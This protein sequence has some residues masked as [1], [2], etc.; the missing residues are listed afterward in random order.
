V[1]SST[2]LGSETRSYTYDA[3]S[4]RLTAT[5]NGTQTVYTY[6][7]TDQLLTTKVNGGSTITDS[8]DPYG[9]L[10]SAV[11]ANGTSARTTAYAYDTLDR[12]TS[13]TP[14]GGT[15]STFAVDALGRHASRTTGGTTET[16]GYAGSAGAVVRI[17]AGA[18]VTN[19]ALDAL[20][21]RLAVSSGASFGWTLP[22]LH[23]DIAA[24][25][26]SGLTSVSDAFRY[27][28]YGGLLASV[29]SATPSPW[30][31]QG[32]LTENTGAGTA[33]LYDFGFRSYAPGLG[34]FTSLDDVTGSA[35]NPLSLN[36]FL[37]AAANPE[38]LVDP[39]GHCFTSGSDGGFDLFGSIGNCVA[40]SAGVVVGVGED[41]VG[42]GG[43]LV[44][45]V[46]SAPGHAADIARCLA[47]DPCW[48]QTASGIR[49]SAAQLAGEIHDRGQSVLAD[50]GAAVSRAT[51]KVAFAAADWVGKE[52]AQLTTTGGFEGGREAGY[53]LGAV[54]IAGLTTVGGGPLASAGADTIR[55]LRSS[56]MASRL[57][58]AVRFG[59]FTDDVDFGARLQGAAEQA[60]NNIPGLGPIRGTRVHSNF[61]SRVHS[62]HLPD[63]DTEVSY[64]NGRRVPYGTRGSVRIDVGVGPAHNL[65]D[66]YDLKTGGARLT[67]AR[68]NQLRTH[69][70][71]NWSIYEVHAL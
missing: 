21:D 38:T 24:Y 33:E 70:P 5:K 55:A 29:T 64:L 46:L 6:D 68:I 56:E 13:E 42:L 32:R 69:V 12:L 53:I 19:A 8:Y 35:Q 54:E 16:Y 41:A 36:R 60:A 10:V 23:G 58:D 30:R 31:Y 37:Y 26:T 50:P 17:S 65:T 43:G 11:D 44:G 2:G 9:N 39:D 59:R 66:V 1:T 14:A 4:N 40:A 61:A 45:G 34:A 7:A 71:G 51:S 57:A 18:T 25:A 3:D 48:N 15:A 63:V 27:D 22:D 20:G 47:D 52:H 67:T 62:W 49:G 28:P